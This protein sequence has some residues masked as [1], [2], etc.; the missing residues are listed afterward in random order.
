MRPQRR[1][2]MTPLRLASR[3]YW[4]KGTWRLQFTN[5]RQLEV[6]C[7]EAPI[8]S[9]GVR[10]RRR[11]SLS[12]R[13]GRCGA[14]GLARGI[15]RRR[16]AGRWKGCRSIPPSLPTPIATFPIPGAPAFSPIAS[17]RPAA[18][19]SG[20]MLGARTEPSDLGPPGRWL[21]DAPDVRTAL[22]GFEQLQSANS[23]GAVFYLRRAA[24]DFILGY[25]VY[26]G[27]ATAHEQAYTLAMASAFAH[28]AARDGRRRPAVRSAFLLSPPQG[29]RALR[30]P[31]RRAGSIRPVRN[32]P[33]LYAGRD[34]GARSSGSKT[35][36]FDFWRKKALEA[37]PPHRSSLDGQRP[38]RAAAVAAGQQGLRAGSRRDAENR[39]QNARPPP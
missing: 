28:F 8:G 22:S 36:N 27:T 2:G 4:H 15:R 24:P 23:H 5:F 30:R 7:C 37:A 14:A 21:A 16:Q 3:G 38:A 9:A 18:G 35:A 11:Q 10:R 17:L 19:I 25:G 1:P 32:R 13:V 39:R 20:C 29:H 6:K 33:R 34:A 26:D 12:A 31:L